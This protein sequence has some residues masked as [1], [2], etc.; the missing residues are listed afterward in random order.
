VGVSRR[1]VI[2]GTATGELYLFDSMATLQKQFCVGK[3]KVFPMLVDPT[4][5]RATGSGGLLTLFEDGA[6]S[7]CVEVTDDSLSVVAC[8][9]AVLAWRKQTAWLINRRAQVLWRA[10]FARRIRSVVCDS[11]GFHVLAGAIYSFRG[12]P[13][14]RRVHQ[15]PGS[16]DRK[17][18]LHSCGDRA[19]SDDAGEFKQEK[20]TAM[21][22]FTI[23]ADHR[24]T[25]FGSREEA[26]ASGVS[27]VDTFE[28][29]RR[30]IAGRAKCPA[31]GRPFSFAAQSLCGR[32]AGLR[33]TQSPAIPAGC[34]FLRQRP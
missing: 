26:E 32:R 24:V 17:G 5:L 25:V 29:R 13:E 30:R 23:D 33:G 3:A 10:E 6:I 19:I 22:I 20:T 12:I 27:D 14:G 7:G 21:K 34:A 2:A 28:L 1:F 4:G 18:E 31:S 15:L 11:T 9:S 16:E 8:G